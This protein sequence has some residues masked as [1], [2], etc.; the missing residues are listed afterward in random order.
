ML[1]EVERRVLEELYPRHPS[2][3]QLAR[4]LGVSHTTIA[5]KLRRYGIGA[6]G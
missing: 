2:S 3:R 5:N 1:G 4:R 6:R